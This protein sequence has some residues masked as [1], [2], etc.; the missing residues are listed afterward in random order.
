M[1]GSRSNHPHPDHSLA[2]FR[3]LTGNFLSM[4]TIDTRGRKKKQR[5]R[6]P[7]PGEDGEGAGDD[8]AGGNS[9]HG[10][11]GGTSSKKK[12]KN[13]SS[14]SQAG[15]ASSS[16]PSQMTMSGKPG[17]PPVKAY[18]KDL[19]LSKAA[20]MMAAWERRKLFEPVMSPGRS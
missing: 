4:E 1:G 8:D 17:A 18:E 15:A 3:I 12:M 7:S 14:S 9:K 2:I 11:G 20:A 16:G 13:K 6:D 10:K 19:H 5:K